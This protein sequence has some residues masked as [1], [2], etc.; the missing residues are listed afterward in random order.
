MRVPALLND[1]HVVYQPVFNLHTGGVM[2]MEAK[3]K[4]S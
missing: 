3:A 1:V 4:P 2:A